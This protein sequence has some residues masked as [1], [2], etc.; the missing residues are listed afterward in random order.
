MASDSPAG[1]HLYPAGVGFTP[2][3]L[4]NL[5]IQILA[6]CEIK[7]LAPRDVAIVS[8]LQYTLLRT[9]TALLGRKVLHTVS[10]YWLLCLL[11]L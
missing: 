7:K 1:A 5:R 6:F 4:I 2:E 11:M 8:L 9:H 3:Q 10:A